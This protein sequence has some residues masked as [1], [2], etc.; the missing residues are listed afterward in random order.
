ML[1]FILSVYNGNTPSDLQ[2]MVAS[3]TVIME[4]VGLI[5]QGVTTAFTAAKQKAKR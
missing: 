5:V 4:K 3:A 2:C 1:G